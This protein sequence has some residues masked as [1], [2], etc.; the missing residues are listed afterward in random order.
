MKILIVDKAA[1]A[2]IVDWA[3]VPCIGDTLDF[4][5][6]PCPQVKTRILYP[7]D[8]TKRE[9]IDTIIKDIGTN[10]PIEKEK[11]IMSLEFFVT[12]Y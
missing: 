10:I 6:L 5:Y 8:Y 2:K 7:S 4:G 1:G 12:T 3:L 9:L 11:E